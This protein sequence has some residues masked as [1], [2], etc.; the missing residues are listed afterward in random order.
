MCRFSRYIEKHPVKKSKLVGRK[1]GRPR[2]KDILEKPELPRKRGR[3]P[4]TDKIENSELSW[5]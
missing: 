2:T 1:V 3:P 4:S 5:K